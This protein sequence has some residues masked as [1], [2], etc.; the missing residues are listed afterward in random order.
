M[1]RAKKE[2]LAPQQID[3]V[4]RLFAVLSEPNRL[5]LLQALLPGTLSVGQLVEATGLKQANVSRHLAVLFDHQLV[6]R[7]RDGATIYY[8][9]ADP[10]IFALC[11]VVCD[12]VRRD[13][14]KITSLF[15]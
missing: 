12:K 7:R 2:L 3:A 11:E 4:A 8:Q 6:S 14:Q 5:Q 15:A 13:A 10:A 1:S 9:I